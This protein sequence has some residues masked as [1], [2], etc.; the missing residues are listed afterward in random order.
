MRGGGWAGIT[1]RACAEGLKAACFDL[2]RAQCMPSGDQECVDVWV[3][4]PLVPWPQAGRLLLSHSLPSPP[5]PIPLS[6]FFPLHAHW[7][8]HAPPPCPARAGEGPGRSG[9]VGGGTRG[10]GGSGGGGTGVSSR[11]R[12]VP[13]GCVPQ[14][15]C[16]EGVAWHSPLTEAGGMNQPGTGLQP[17]AISGGRSLLPDCDD[18]PVQSEPVAPR[19]HWFL[20]WPGVFWTACNCWSASVE[21]FPESAS[22]PMAF[23]T[24]SCYPRSRLRGVPRATAA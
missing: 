14:L 22:R 13:R 21:G 20:T 19:S 10:S 5:S 1:R 15:G 4:G 16:P 7:P 11:S 6:P 24:A 12:L 8:F 18:P 23:L 9:G 3:A 2:A 17:V